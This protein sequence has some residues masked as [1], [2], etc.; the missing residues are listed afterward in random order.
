MRIVIAWTVFGF[1]AVA[2]A[3]ALV[4]NIV[5]AANWTGALGDARRAAGPCIEETLTNGRDGQQCWHPQHRL[6][7][8]ESRW[9]CRCAPPSE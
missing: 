3:A 6:Y 8:G 2:V 1:V 9:V 4:M 7:E 5:V